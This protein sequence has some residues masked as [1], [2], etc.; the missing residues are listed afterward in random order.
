MK[1]LPLFY[2]VVLLLIISCNTSPQKSEDTNNRTKEKMIE[3]KIETFVASYLNKKDETV[4]TDV[5]DENYIRH[6]NG[7]TVASNS[8]ELKAAMN[9]FFKGFADLQIT[10]ESRCIKDGEAFVHFTFTGTNTGIFA[11]A[12][13]TGKKVKISGLSHLY[14]NNEGKIYQED[15][16]YNELDF[17]QQLGH[18]LIPPITE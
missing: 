11:E 15:I 16:Y 12:V 2:I 8:Q 7:I 14:F 18:S 4:L 5:L 1:T 3:A 6:I 13:A 9:I 10:N 17:L